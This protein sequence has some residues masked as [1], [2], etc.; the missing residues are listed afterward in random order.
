M[1][2]RDQGDENSTG[3]HVNIEFVEQLIALVSR[4]PICELELKRD[5]WHVRIVKSGTGPTGEGR[6]VDPHPTPEAAPALSGRAS[7]GEPAHLVLAGLVGTFYRSPAPG[8]PPFV[9]VGDSVEEGQTLGLLEAMKTMIAVQA[10]RAGR[11][12]IIHC[13]DSAPVQ[14]GATLFTIDRAD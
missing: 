6:L 1:L 3:R 4:S 8:Q 7:L 2:V 11:V 9:S 10:D 13:E 12:M 14:A 5:G